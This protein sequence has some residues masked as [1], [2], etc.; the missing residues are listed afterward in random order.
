[1]FMITMTKNIK[2]DKSTVSPEEA[3][4]VAFSRQERWIGPNP[5]A[6]QQ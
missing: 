4:E 1:V 5:V 2:T 6:T 3:K